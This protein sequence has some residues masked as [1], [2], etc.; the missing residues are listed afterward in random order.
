[1]KYQVKQW[2]SHLKYNSLYK[3]AL[4]KHCLEKKHNFKVETIVLKKI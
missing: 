4:A 3:S 1:M 2:L